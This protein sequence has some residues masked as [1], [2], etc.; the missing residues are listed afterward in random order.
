MWLAI[1][2]SVGLIGITLAAIHFIYAKIDHPDVIISATKKVTDFIHDA[3]ASLVQH[4]KPP[5]FK[6]RPK[7]S[8]GMLNQ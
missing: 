1:F 8:A 6:I 3:F 7:C 4:E 2:G 5:N